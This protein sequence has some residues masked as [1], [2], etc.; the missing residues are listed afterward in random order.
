[1]LRRHLLVANPF[2]PFQYAPA[3]WLDASD[4]S[5]LYKERTGSSATTLVAS[6]ADPVGTWRDKSGNARHATAASDAKR[7]TYKTGIQNSKSV[8]RFDGVDDY[9]AVTNPSSFAGSNLT[10]FSISKFTA[11]TTQSL[12]SCTS[13]LLAVNYSG[14]TAHNFFLGGGANYG[15]Y[16]ASGGVYFLMSAVYD[17]SLAAANRIS[18]FRNGASKTLTLFGTIP[19]TTGSISAATIGAYVT[20]SL[21]FLNGDV[22][23][24]IVYTSSLSTSQR[25][26]VE[27]Y[28][29]AKWGITL[30]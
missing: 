20:G 13:D 22:C 24:M 23:E 25:Q 19:T 5:T 11:G 9:F 2:N 21:Q 16:T 3:L 30:S 26:Q 14:S 28:L 17:G 1:M 4:Q 10:V 27:R 7:P 18:L 15:Q 8:I 29:S 6:D 12:L